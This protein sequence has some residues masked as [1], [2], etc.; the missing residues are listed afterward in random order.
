M[1]EELKQMK[2][3]KNNY[4]KVKETEKLRLNNETT[5]LGKELELIMEEQNKLKSESAEINS[6]KLGKV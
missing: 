1:E 6:K 2:E 5:N 4:I 3:R